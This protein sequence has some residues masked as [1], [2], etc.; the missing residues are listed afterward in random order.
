MDPCDADRQRERMVQQQIAA[1][2]VRAPRVLQAMRTV[3]REAFIDD[4]LRDAAF[5]D[6]PLPIGEQQTLSQP[7]IVA[8]MI[9]A[10]DLQGDE[11]VLEVGTGSGYASAVL[12]CLARQ[13]FSI[14]RFASLAASAADRLAALGFGQVQVRQGDGTLGWSEQAPFD[15]ILVSAS[16]PRVPPALKAQLAIGGR[17]VMPV[18]RDREQQELLR[19][20]RVAESRFSTRRLGGVRFVPLIGEEGWAS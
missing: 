14:E 4:M 13:V 11:R 18:G 5:D 12:A 2:G 9:E 19:L 10:L 8:L 15:A 20:T 17:L 7:Y 6:G 3:P 16:G 1:R